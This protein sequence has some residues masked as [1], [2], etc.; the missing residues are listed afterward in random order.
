M[1][2]N[3]YR[4]IGNDKISYEDV[5]HLNWSGHEGNDME[6]MLAGIANYLVAVYN[7]TQLDSIYPVGSI[8]MSVNSTSPATLFG[9]SWERLQNRFLVGAGSTYSAGSTGGSATD[10]VEIDISTSGGLASHHHSFSYNK[11]SSASVPTDKVGLVTFN[12][13]Y[14]GGLDAQGIECN[15]RYIPIRTSSGSISASVSST[16]SSGTTGN[17]GSG[18]GGAS[19]SDSAVVDTVPPYLSVYMWK[20]IE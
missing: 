6:Q 12:D 13:E 11:A 2:A 10:T 14:Q 5:F 15:Y 18:S 9:G 4:L 3:D 20:R 7:S 1:P 17:A 19:G 16:S 8:Y